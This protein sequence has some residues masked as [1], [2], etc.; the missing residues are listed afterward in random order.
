MLTFTESFSSEGHMFKKQAKESLLDLS[1]DELTQ[2]NSRNL[3]NWNSSRPN[4]TP[5]VHIHFGSR[6][7]TSSQKTVEIYSNR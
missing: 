1:M 5:A 6:T 3:L 2:H 4:I 7:Y